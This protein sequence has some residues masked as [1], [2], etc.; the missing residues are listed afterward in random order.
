MPR[1]TET[2]AA[3]GT[4]DTP[5]PEEIHTAHASPRPVSTGATTVSAGVALRATLNTTSAMTSPKSSPATYGMTPLKSYSPRIRAPK[6]A[7][8][9]PAPAATT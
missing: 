5:R 3:A 1:A 2:K 6:A 4:G 9:A 8:A 7:E